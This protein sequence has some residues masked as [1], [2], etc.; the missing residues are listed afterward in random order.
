MLSEI[1]RLSLDRSEGDRAVKPFII[2]SLGTNPV[3]S[4]FLWG[5]LIAIESKEMGVRSRREAGPKR[6][7]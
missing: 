5:A 3:V 7:T 4:A 6:K 1:T 2:K